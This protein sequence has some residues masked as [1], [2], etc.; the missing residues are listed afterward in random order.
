MEQRDSGESE[1][2]CAR[3]CPRSGVRRVGGGPNPNE[4]LGRRRGRRRQNR[5]PDL[6]RRSGWGYGARGPR[7]LRPSRYLRAHGR[8]RFRSH[9]SPRLARPA[10]GWRAD[11][12]HSRRTGARR[13]RHRDRGRSGRDTS[14]RL[15]LDGR[16]RLGLRSGFCDGRRRRRADRGGRSLGRSGRRRRGNASFRQ[17]R[18]RVDVA[19]GVVGASD[20]EV[21][22]GHLNLRVARRADRPD[23]LSLDDAVAG[24]DRQ[25][26]QVQQGYRVTIGRPDRQRTAVRRQRAR[27]R[28]VTGCGCAHSL[29]G[30]GSDVDPGM[31]VFAVLGTAELEAPEHRAVDGPRPRKCRRGQHQPDHESRQEIRCCLRRQH[32]SRK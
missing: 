15:S 25:R 28:D 24:A 5:S 23:D 31:A 7:P 16:R 22:V 21:D 10:S 6:G 4:R 29:T 3:Q 13:P 20:P 30:S 9:L 1:N 27:K 18:Q 12:R 19:L 11:P 2:G 26:A 8:L 32:R 14:H 17:E